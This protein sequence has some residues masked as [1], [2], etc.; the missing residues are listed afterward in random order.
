MGGQERGK[1][2]NLSKVCYIGIDHRTTIPFCSVTSLPAG[3]AMLDKSSPL[4][5]YFQLKELLREKIASGEWQPGD[6]V[7]SERELSE[8]YHISRMTARQALRELATEG[9]LRREPGRGTFVAAPKIEHGLS[10]LTG[11]TEDMLARGLQPGAKVI[12]LALISPPLRVA[13][14]LQITPDRKIVLLERLRLAGGEP[15]ALESS[16]LYF[17]GVSALLNEDFENHSLYHILS[18]KYHITPARA[19]QKIGADLCSRREQ[20]LLQIAEGAP[21]LRNK[22]ITYDQW[23]RPFEYTESAYRGDRYVFQAELS[24]LEQQEV[25]H[26]NRENPFS[27]DSYPHFT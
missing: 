22:R 2:D 1:L 18:E 12:R 25:S 27:V 23:G 9:L 10:R 20:E 4:P 16:H 3:G 7:P 26:V 19:V 13:R 14:A 11:F 21:V 17:N 5:L 24:A 15:V 6:M 8:Q